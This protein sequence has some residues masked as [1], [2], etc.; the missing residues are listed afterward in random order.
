MINMSVIIVGDGCRGIRRVRRGALEWD[1]NKKGYLGMRMDIDMCVLCMYNIV[2]SGKFP[3]VM[4]G[5]GGRSG[6]LKMVMGG[7]GWSETL[8]DDLT[9]V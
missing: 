9:W 2:W 4:H 3:D 1:N 6:G 7:Q 8:K 5:I